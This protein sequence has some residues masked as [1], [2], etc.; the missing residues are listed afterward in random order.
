MNH[1]FYC[2][3]A[4]EHREGLWTTQSVSSLQPARDFVAW[5]VDSLAA[6]SLTS[7]SSQREFLGFPARNIQRSTGFLQIS[8]PL[9]GPDLWASGKRL[10]LRVSFFRHCSLV[11]FQK[12]YFPGISRDA[13]VQNMS[14]YGC[15]YVCGLTKRQQT[16]RLI[17]FGSWWCFDPVSCVSFCS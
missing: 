5:E 10:P 12:K 7:A 3:T 4:M 16:R 17:I 6:P 14:T 13:V 1:S 2:S 15:S 8:L 9:I 11:I